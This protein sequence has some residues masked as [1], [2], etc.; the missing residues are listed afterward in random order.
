MEAPP[1][2]RAR[3]VSAHSAKLRGVSIVRPK[4]LSPLSTPASLLEV[5]CD[6]W[7]LSSHSTHAAAPERLGVLQWGQIISEDN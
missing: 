3:P 4:T 1:D 7:R 2:S 6:G 5:G